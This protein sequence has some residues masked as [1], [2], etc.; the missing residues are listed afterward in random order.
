MLCFM[1]KLLLIVCFAL[2][3]HLSFGQI[4]EGDV[5][6]TTQAEVDAFSCETVLG[7]VLI[8]G[9]DITSLESL[10]VLKQVDEHFILQG[11]P[12]LESLAG[13][14]N[15]TDV[16]CSFEIKD[17][18]GLVDLQGLSSLSTIGRNLT[19]TDC[20]RLTSLNGLNEVTALMNLQVWNNPVLSECCVL[21]SILDVVIGETSIYGNAPS[22][23]LEA[24]AYCDSDIEVCVGDIL[25]STQ[26]QMDA[27]NCEK[28]IGNITINP[29]LATDDPVYSIDNL[30]F[31]TEVT[32]DLR[33]YEIGGPINMLNN[34][35][36]AHSIQV[37][38]VELDLN[39]LS[40]LEHLWGIDTRFAVVT[41]SFPKLAG[42]LEYVAFETLTVLQE[43]FWM[44]NVDH[45]Q[46]LGID[47]SNVLDLKPSFQLLR[48]G[49][50]LFA[51][52]VSDFDGLQHI[53]SLSFLDFQAVRPPN[54]DQLSGLVFADTL[55]VRDMVEFPDDYCGLYPVLSNRG[56]SSIFRWENNSVEVN[57]ILANCG[58][59]EIIC[60]GDVEI[61]TQND[62]D[63]FFCTVI[64]GNLQIGDYTNPQNNADLETSNLASLREVKG[65]L[66]I[67]GNALNLAGLSGIERIGGSLVFYPGISS[68]AASNIIS[69]DSL[70]SLKSVRE[71]KTYYYT[72]KG[73]LTA[74]E[75]PI[76]R[77]AIEGLAVIE[78]PTFLGTTPY[79]DTLRFDLAKPA[80]TAPSFQKLKNGSSI[81]TWSIKS[82]DGL[83]HIDSLNLFKVANTTL[84][85][86]N[87]INNLRVVNT[88]DWVNVTLPDEYCEIYPLLSNRNMFSLLNW[89]NNSVSL[90]QILAECG[91]EEIKCSGSFFIENQQDADEL[92]CNVIDG[93]LYISVNRLETVETE[94]LSRLK[95][96]TGLL[97][98][99]D[100]FENV[101]RNGFRNLEY[102]GGNLI[103]DSSPFNLNDLQS[104]KKTNI[105]TCATCSLSGQLP[106]YQ[107]TLNVLQLVVSNIDETVDFQNVSVI[108]EM[109]VVSYMESRIPGLE[110]LAEG[111]Y[112]RVNY[113]FASE[114][115]DLSPLA[116]IEYLSSL[117]IDNA[118]LKSYDGLE[119]LSKV[120]DLD[121]RQNTILGDC[122]GFYNFLTSGIITHS[123]LY[124]D[125]SC[126][127]EE[128]IASCAPEEV[129]AE[130]SVYPNPAA[131][132][133]IE[134]EYTGNPEINTTIQVIDNSGREVS[135]ETLEGAV[136]RQHLELEISGLE[137][138]F[139]LIRIITGDEVQLKRLIRQ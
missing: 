18:D 102:V 115:I 129:L 28:V 58:D 96:V 132:N 133:S 79:V 88:M 13:L 54:F 34:L 24:L 6:L 76:E 121:F 48:N 117:L 139:Y 36:S 42:T 25:I 41:G 134:I 131:S 118:T 93:D 21:N 52:G 70:S 47:I 37:V 136:G 110:K 72:V 2:M 135:L 112:L 15:L 74:I 95:E 8:T 46:R 67:Q 89:E 138:G 114:G 59:E 122:C 98:F 44:G 73:E 38:A 109:H 31:L 30:S 84:E 113:A 78:T 75:E 29:S 20:D 99:S 39:S 10:R 87:G 101:S 128:I 55:I 106:A 56:A 71:I 125:N 86:M 51:L 105:L 81:D 111:G 50:S 66:V 40:S 82:L 100:S 90:N 16:T 83:Q 91:N 53:D 60:R 108:N 68:S 9:P 80:D 63:N 23:S 119:T 22:C 43:P 124:E 97:W 69:L 85:N 57:E 11:L 65:G 61:K 45:V 104:L 35:T 126:T 26:A 4:C 49:G 92:Y 64:E 7:T 120:D 5:V 137:Q 94:N 3:F 127:V 1:K 62:A 32:G 107:D 19:V 12:A 33:I 27:F 17:C 14:E 123:F 130:M 116:G 103:F 77:V